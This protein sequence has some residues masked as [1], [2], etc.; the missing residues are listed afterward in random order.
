MARASGLF[1]KLPLGDFGLE[2]ITPPS[3]AAHPLDGGD[4][5]LLTNSAEET[6]RLL[7]VDGVH[8]LAWIGSIAR[9]WSKIAPSIWTPLGVPKHPLAFGS[10]ASRAL[11]PA[12]VFAKL[13]F[14]SAKARAL[15]AGN[16]AH[17]I[18]PLS[19][20]GSAAIGLVLAAVAHVHGWPVPKGGSRAIANALCGYLQSLGGKIITGCKVESHRQLPEAKILLFDTSPRTAARILGERLPRGYSRALMRYPYGPGV[21]KID[22]ALSEPIPWRGKGC[23]SAATVHVG[24]SLEEIAEA[25]R[26]VWL[27]RGAERPFVLVTQP[28]L[29]D[30]TRAPPGKHTAWGYCHVPNGWDIDMTERIEGQIERFAPG[31]RQTILARVAR[32][33]SQLELENPNCVGGDVG[34]GSN[35]LL[36]LLF[37]PT[38]RTYSTP[39]KGV[40]LCSAATPPGGGVH[41]MCGY[42]AAR[43]AIRTHF[44]SSGFR[45]SGL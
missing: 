34:G 39:A 12:T 44:G 38:W 40:Y 37:R 20:P 22:W 27:G 19:S 18:L 1:S 4:A 10:F 26:S 23:R 32:S 3:A 7:G 42:N 6:A 24:G 8:Y 5:A 36:N 25:E 30:E 28:S 21:F 16:A 35:R 15:F 9:N 14:S 13:A 41:G 11:L 31:F 29:F 43:R 45:N 33:S 17:A 2:W